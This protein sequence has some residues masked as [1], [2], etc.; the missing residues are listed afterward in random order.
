MKG[1]DQ[2]VL[3]ASCEF[4][5]SSFNIMINIHEKWS[6][7]E[8][9]LRKGDVKAMHFLICTLKEIIDSSRK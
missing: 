3:A 2:E 6:W 4:G 9:F 1:R 7:I 5:G 8:G